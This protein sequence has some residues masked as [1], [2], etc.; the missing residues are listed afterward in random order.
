MREFFP[1]GWDGPLPET[2]VPQQQA[3]LTTD[4]GIAFRAMGDMERAEARR[5]QP[6]Y[7]ESFFIEA[8]KRLG[9]SIREREARR[10]EL[11]H[12]P[13]PVRNRDR[14]IGMGDPVLAKYERIAFEKPLI[15]PPGQP[16]AAFV[17]PGHPLLDA[18][19][20]LTLERQRDLMKRGA[21]LVETEL[22]ARS[23]LGSAEFEVFL[24]EFKAGVNAYLAGL[25]ERVHERVADLAALGID[26]SLGH[27]A[28]T[29]EE[30]RAGYAAGAR[31]TTAGRS[32]S[33]TT[34]AS[35][36]R[37]AASTAL[38]CAAVIWGLN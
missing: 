20:D 37:A 9:G 15:A 12:V 3:Y 11:A 8:F 7:V 1:Q 31:T 21:V 34:G 19:L 10:F 30:A 32:T 2:L 5:L 27:S 35:G 14:Q 24:Y 33:A 17:C 38:T 29:L 22:P 36:W 23:K 26:A 16:L 18:V 6:H 25:G 13:A 28:A 4:L